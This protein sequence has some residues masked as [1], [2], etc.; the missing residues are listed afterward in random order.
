MIAMVTSALFGYREVIER[1]PQ[2]FKIS[3]L[4]DIKAL[5]APTRNPFHSGF[6]NKINV[7]LCVHSTFNDLCDVLQ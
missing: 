3:C 6:G 1:R 4:R 2:D 5:F 7:R